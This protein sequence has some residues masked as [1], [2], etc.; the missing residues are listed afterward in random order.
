MPRSA[1]TPR[2]KPLAR[3]RF[4]STRP[5]GSCCEPVVGAAARCASA[6][7]AKV[8]TP[9]AAAPARAVVFR[10]DLRSC[11]MAFLLVTRPHG[12]LAESLDLFPMRRSGV[13]A[14]AGRIG[15]LCK[16]KDLPRRL[17]STRERAG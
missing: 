9:A 16:I 3:L 11:F 1:R 5:R 15:G 13:D 4:A 8:P 6:G 10:K 2:P 7:A 12:T 14:A 17:E